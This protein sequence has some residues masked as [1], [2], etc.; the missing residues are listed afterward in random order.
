MSRRLTGVYR[1]GRQDRAQR[2][3][4]RHAGACRRNIPGHGRPLLPMS[5]PHPYRGSMVAFPAC[6]SGIAF[7]LP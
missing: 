1:L 7:L 4:Q 2:P 6:A 3:F 5:L